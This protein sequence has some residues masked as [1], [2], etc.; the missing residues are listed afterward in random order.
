MRDADGGHAEDGDADGSDDKADDGGDD[1]PARQL[2]EM[3]GEDQVAGAEEHT[4]QRPGHQNFLPHGQFFFTVIAIS[5]F[6]YELII[7]DILAKVKR[8]III[9]I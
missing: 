5:S 1:V 7:K 2:A 4:E 3:D 9:V 8:G 6:I